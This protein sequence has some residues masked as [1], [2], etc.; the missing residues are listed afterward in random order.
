MKKK[1]KKNIQNLV[2]STK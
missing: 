2:L 1:T